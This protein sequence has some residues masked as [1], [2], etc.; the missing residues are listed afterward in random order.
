MTNPPALLSGS[1]GKAHSRLAHPLT[2]FIGRKRELAEVKALLSRTR[3]LTLT[4]VGGC[5]K[6]R[7]A[8]QVAT[9]LAAEATRFPHGVVWV[10]LAALSDP[11]LVPQAVAA[12]LE[13]REARDEPLVETLCRALQG[14]RLLLV[15]DNCEHVLAACAQL[16]EALLRA[17]PR[18]QILATSREPLGIMGE[19]AWLVPSLSLPDAG[20]MA[21][22]EGHMLSDHSSFVVRLASSEA[23][24]L[25]VERAAAVRAD[26]ALTPEN[27]AAVAQICWRL[28]GLPLA[29][30]LAAARV[31]VLT[32]GQVAARLDDRFN[33]LTAGNRTALIPRH[34]TLRAAMDWSYN[35]LSEPERVVFRR[36]AVF[37]G[38]FT[39]EA[40]EAVCATD[41]VLELLA[42]LVDKSLVMAELHEPEGARYRLLETIRQYA[43]EQLQASG[44]GDELQQR[45]AA[46][47]LALA[48]TARPALGGPQG[49]AWLD[50][51][52]EEHDNL[53]AALGWSLDDGD[54]EM[55]LRLA[56]AL[57]IFWRAH[58]HHREGHIWMTRA[59]ER[60]PAAP[61]AVRAE[62]LRSA[63][64]IACGQGHYAVA[65]SLLE[66]SLALAQA[67][68]DQLAV[69]AALYELGIVAYSQ[70]DDGTARA[71]LDESLARQRQLHDQPGMVRTLNA[72]GELAR[73]VGD[74]AQAEALYHEGLGISRE[75]GDVY[76]LSLQLANLGY[77]ALHRG[78][79]AGAAPLFE[80]SLNLAQKRGDRTQIALCLAGLA[81]VAGAQGWAVRAARLLGAAEALLERTGA[82]LDP[83]DRADYDRIV[84]VVRAALSADVLAAAWAE[85]RAL[86]LDRANA[87][88]LE[89]TED[90]GRLTEATVPGP[91]SSVVG[92]QLRLLALGP[93]QVVRGE[94]VLTPSDWTYAK[95]KELLFYLLCHT[96]RTREQI[97]LALWPDA[98]PA[99][100]R[101]HLSNSL[102][103]LRRALGRPEWVVFENDA[104]A[105]NRALTAWEGSPA[106]WFDLEAFESHLAA[107]RRLQDTAQAIHHLE[108]AIALVRG[109]F[110]EDFSQGDWFILQREE[111]RRK[112]LEALLALGRLHFEQAEY[113][114][115][116][117]AYRRAIAQDSYLEAAHR[118]LMRCY[119]RLGERGGAL[120]HY[121]ALVELMRD[122]LGAPPAPETTALFERL[123]RGEE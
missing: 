116:A 4:G 26:F 105:F 42:R 27:A 9:D 43:W 3:L 121:Q 94:R 6:T 21:N 68:E 28:D 11:A 37:A 115:A 16:A 79:E 74:D 62:A 7:L 55:G 88:A 1:Q 87:Y 54:A 31:R 69:A 51:L 81:G 77:L 61:S 82:R 110:L 34:Q 91:P 50:R 97:G 66:Q 29:L 98:S 20:R 118:G 40:A 95:V 122:E 99:R 48:E 114:R 93:A 36:L 76:G 56:V 41:Q 92:Q 32:V 103:H 5:G 49:P 111:I 64:R 102:Y 72:L 119:A 107:A 25:F 52:E 80:E 13:I 45:H 12:A 2:S 65:R 35:L 117:E 108:E 44:E 89:R 101:S 63:G 8:L 85:G 104:Y 71:L 47:Y 86:T 57:A 70:R 53:R 120:R 112:H 75:L 123:R 100:L 17:C 113:G 58:N 10:E 23:V 78:D 38:G 22:D 109:E 33:L 46:Y 96:A 60:N 90:G 84:E 106:Y 19:N 59:L 14:R 83:T 15:L 39:L 73:V 30:E 24:Q 18:L 67:L